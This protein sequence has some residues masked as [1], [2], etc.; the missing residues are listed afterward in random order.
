MFLAILL[1]RIL[2]IDL[3]DGV[4]T[5]DVFVIAMGILGIIL[6][7]PLLYFAWRCL[8]EEHKL[9]VEI[10]SLELERKEKFFPVQEEVSQRSVRLAILRGLP[11][12][13]VLL[14][15][16]E[17]RIEHGFAIFDWVLLSAVVLIYAADLICLEWYRTE[18]TKSCMEQTS[19]LITPPWPRGATGNLDSPSSPSQS[20]LIDAQI[21]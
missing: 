15:F 2:P 20:P 8:N 21:A 13:M 3:D 5:L 9:M 11:I 1:D 16:W 17:A 10:A 12:F 19:T 6:Y 18:A 4:Q 14:L 7:F